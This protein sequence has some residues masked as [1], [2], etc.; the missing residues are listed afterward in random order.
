MF[1]PHHPEDLGMILKFDELSLK[2]RMGDTALTSKVQF[3]DVFE[4]S[5]NKNAIPFF[6]E[7]TFPT[8][9]EIC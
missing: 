1:F 9:D 5:P 4:D 3:D 6:Q 8:H 2:T 7:S